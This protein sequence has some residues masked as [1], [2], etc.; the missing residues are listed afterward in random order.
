VDDGCEFGGLVVGEYLNPRGA[1]FRQ[2]VAAA[3]KRSSSRDLRN[4]SA[5]TVSGALSG[6]RTP[7]RRRSLL[8]ERKFRLGPASMI[9]R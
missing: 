2:T 9:G 5:C 8:I 6:P 4:T 1:N 7:T 3:Q